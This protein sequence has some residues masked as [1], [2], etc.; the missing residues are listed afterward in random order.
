MDHGVNVIRPVLGGCPFIAV[1]DLLSCSKDRSCLIHLLW[2]H[3][4][5]DKGVGQNSQG[6][7]PYG[8]SKTADDALPLH[9]AE[10]GYDLILPHPQD[11]TPNPLRP[12][13]QI[14]SIL[15]DLEKL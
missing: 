9:S 15:S 12:L 1:S 11:L 10:T 3:P 14:Q 13:R 2:R 7:V 5:G 6:S 4:P 8:G